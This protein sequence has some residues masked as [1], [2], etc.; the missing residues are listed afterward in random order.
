[1]IIFLSLAKQFALPADLLAEI[2]AS[3]SITN[4]HDLL[5]VYERWQKTGSRHLHARLLA[6]G[7]VPSANPSNDGKD[8]DKPS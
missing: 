1:M 7:I 4:D 2:S 8:R 6:Q 3:Q 5:R